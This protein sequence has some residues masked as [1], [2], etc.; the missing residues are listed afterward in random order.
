MIVYWTHRQ[1]NVS[2]EHRNKT[3]DYL[4]EHGQERDDAAFY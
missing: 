2:V 3:V 1:N 4:N